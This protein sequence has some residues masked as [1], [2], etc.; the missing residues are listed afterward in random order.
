MPPGKS[1]F[2]P[3]FNTVWGGPPPFG[4]CESAEDCD[5]DALRALAE[6]RIAQVTLLEADVDGVALAN[7]YNY[8]AISPVFS[9]TF[10]EDNVFG[11]PAGPFAPL[12]SDGYFLMLAPLSAGD[13]TVHFHA[14]RTR[15]NGTTFEVEVTYQLTVAR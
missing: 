8:R 9:V 15:P 14:V 3:L 1:L 12:V 5:I 6:G 13:H 11:I 2:F 10:P 7:L 4:D